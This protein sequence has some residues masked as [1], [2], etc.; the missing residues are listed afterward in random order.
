MRV[1]NHSQPRRTAAPISLS[2]RSRTIPRNVTPQRQDRRTFRPGGSPFRLTANTVTIA[3]VADYKV[4]LDVYSGPLDLLLYLIRRN[5]VDIYDI[6]IAAVTRQYCQYVECLHR[7]DPDMAAEFLV[8]AAVL[9]EIKSRMLLPSVPDEEGGGEILDDPRT[10]LV[11]R[12]LEYKRFKDASLE[13][14]AALSTQSSRWPRHPILALSRDPQEYDL[15]DVQ[16]WDLV[17]AF[18]QLMVA[19]GRDRATHEVIFDDTP[20]ALHATD[21]LDRLTREGN[22]PFT[23]I[24][25]GRNK[26]EMIGL[27]LAL[28]ELIR[29]RRVRIEQSGLF[30]T[31]FV[32]LLNAEPITVGAEWEY[33]PSLAEEETEN[34]QPNASAEPRQTEDREAKSS[35][36]WPDADEDNE[37]EDDEILAR[38]NQIRT[39]VDVDL[40]GDGSIGVPPVRS[41]DPPQRG[42]P[43]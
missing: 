30:G 42:D 35:V 14:G 17:A 26:A 18:N 40:T 33:R 34:D 7:I 9:M 15:E 10:D 37:Q 25:A 3:G 4:Q 39:D 28:L 20:I 36:D 13:L 41:D 8:M 19:I 16:V 31:I 2:P 38:L 29:Q 43:E 21:I 11:R 32:T 5:E 23:E 1:G 6:P 27:F 24:F 12:L 22:L